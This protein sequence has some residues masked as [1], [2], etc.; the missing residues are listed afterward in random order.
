MIDDAVADYG[1]RTM[2]SPA[3]VRRPASPPW[4]ECCIV[5]THDRPFK[6]GGEFMM[7]R[8]RREQRK[9]AATTWSGTLLAL[10]GM[11]GAGALAYATWV[12]P[13]W[14]EVTDVR[15]TLP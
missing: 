3:I 5:N 11:A 10:G 6:F 4:P 7:S 13:D 14:I 9:A 15:L 12:E 8:Y 2:V 1:R